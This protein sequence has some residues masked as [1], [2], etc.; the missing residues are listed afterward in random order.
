[1]AGGIFVRLDTSHVLAFAA[2]LGAVSADA[3]EAAETAV[4]KTAM[5]IETDAKVLA[6]VD[7]GFLRSSISTD[8]IGGGGGVTAEVGPTAYYG[9]FVEL[10][11][12][13]NAPQPYLLPAFDSHIAELETALAAVTGGFL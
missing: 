1:M 11:T 3:Q 7:T 12:S 2:E 4:R 13:R 10:G 5:D 8:I 9:G 6:P